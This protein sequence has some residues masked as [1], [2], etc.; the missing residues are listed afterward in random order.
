MSVHAEASNSLPSGRPKG[1]AAKFQEESEVASSRSMPRQEAS[2][3]LNSTGGASCSLA[4]AR[5]YLCETPKQE[6]SLIRSFSEIVCRG[7]LNYEGPDR[8]ESLI[9]SAR[10]FKQSQGSP[11]LFELT[12]VFGQAHER[13]Q[14]PV[15]QF[16]PL[17]LRGQPAR[18]QQ[19]VQAL[20]RRPSFS[21][22]PLAPFAP[23]PPPPPPQLTRRPDQPQPA[24]WMS[25]AGQTEGRRHEQ[26]RAGQGQGKLTNKRKVAAR[27]RKSEA[28]RAAGWRRLLLGWPARRVSGRPE[29][30]AVPPPA[31]RQSR[32]RPPSGRLPLFRPT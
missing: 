14:R 12:G 31:T 15:F 4:Q 1:V 30:G 2:A 13:P 28:R 7:C 17:L 20:P 26:V 32:R 6:Y 10:R 3:P 23:P 18:Q 25:P 8:I 16:E 29:P 5:C 19:I 27:Q 24:G 11:S 21:P 9:G 22:G